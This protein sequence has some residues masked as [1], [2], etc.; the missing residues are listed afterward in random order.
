MNAPHIPTANFH[1]QKPTCWTINRSFYCR[2]AIYVWFGKLKGLHLL[3]CNP[4]FHMCTHSKKHFTYA[5]AV[6]SG[7]RNRPVSVPGSLGYNRM[8]YSILLFLD[9]AHGACHGLSARKSV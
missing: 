7:I 9:R 3:E 4:F 5:T 2:A 8:P 6:H 1:L